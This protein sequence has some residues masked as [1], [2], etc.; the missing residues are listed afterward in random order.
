VLEPE[1]PVRIDPERVERLERELLPL[2]VE[3]VR[4]EPVR[5]DAVFTRP[6]PV[7]AVPAPPGAAIP[8][9]LQYPSSIVPEQPVL[10]QRP[11]ALEPA[12]CPVEAV[13]VAAARGAAAAAPAMPHVLQ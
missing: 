11:L 4:P 7:A 1:R 3:G 8:Q 2:R 6:L 9:T 5:V 10:E 12:A 13:E